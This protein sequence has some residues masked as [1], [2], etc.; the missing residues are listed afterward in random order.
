MELPNYNHLL[1]FWMVAREGTIAAAC[2]QLYLTQSTISTQIGALE[3]RLGVK[4]FRRVGRNLVLTETGQAVYHYANEIFAL[5]SELVAVARDHPTSR[6]TRLNIGAH[7]TLPKLIVCRLLEPAFNLPDPVRVICH[8]GTPSQLL[9]KLSTHE[10]D[11]VFSDAP[12]DPQ[13]KVRAFSHPL[14]ECGVAFFAVPDLARRLRQGFPGSFSGAPALLPAA[15]AAMR[16]TLERWFH[17]TGVR[18]IVV[19][20][21]EDIELMIA[22]GQQGRGFFP[23]HDVITAQ[24]TRNRQVEWIG[25]IKG[26]TER[27]YAI[28]VERRLKHP[29]VVAI[30]EAARNVLFA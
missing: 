25:S 27:F 11:L 3:K 7:D 24:V 10:V 8:E 12:M 20:E 28:S 2:K 13:I 23:A 22:F 5:G 17:T 21:S 18:P 29:A 26:H 6:P 1:Y 15:T 4:L 9:P 19:A 30:T 16:G 14:G